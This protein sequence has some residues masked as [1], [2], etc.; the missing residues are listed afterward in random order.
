MKFSVDTIITS[1]FPRVIEVWEASVRA[2][3]DFLREEDIQY[4]KPL[5]LNKYLF[6]VE[7]RAARDLSGNILGFM[8]VA[9]NKIEMLFIHPDV[10]GKGIGKLLVEYAIRQMD[11][12]TVDVNEQNLQAVKF[13]EH[14]GFKI[15]ARSA[16]D[17]LG[18]PYPILSM[19]LEK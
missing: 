3:H 12:R 8:G 18:K 19:E 6:L 15:V 16:T 11:A 5:I 9:H 4:F 2:T 13:Y 7:L 14:L 1:E 10:R 17:S